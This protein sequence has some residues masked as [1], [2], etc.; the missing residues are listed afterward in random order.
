MP[1]AAPQP[2]RARRPPPPARPRP[3]SAR[4]GRARSASA[5]ASVTG[6]AS[7][8]SSS[9]RLLTEPAAGIGPIYQL[10]AGAR[11]SVDLTIYELNDP[12]AEAD[13]T[14]DAAR[15]VNVRVLLDQHLE[16]SRN[17]AAY[18]YLAARR[19]HVRWAPSGTTYHQKTLTVD[20]A[21]SVIMTLNLVAE[22]YP[23]TRDFAVIDTSHAD[24]A[25]IAATFDA[26]FAGRPIT[27][28][29]GTDLVWSPTNAQASL[30]SVIDNATHSLAVEDEEMDDPTVT[31]ALAAAAHRGVNVTITMTANSDWDSA[32]AQLAQAGAHIHLYPDDSSSLYIHAK[33]LVADAGR[34]SQQALVGSQNFSVAS[35]DYNR[36][37]GILT[38]AKPLITSLSAT[39]AS[40][41]SG[42][43]PYAP[44][45]TSTR[46]PA[47]ASSARCT[48]TAT[49][50]NAARNENNVYVHSNQPDQEATATAAGYSHTYRTNS[51]GYALIYLNGPSPGAR[52][53]VTVGAATCTTTLAMPTS[54]CSSA[55]GPHAAEISYAALE[56]FGEAGVDG[57]LPCGIAARWLGSRLLG[58][59]DAERCVQ[60]TVRIGRAHVLGDEQQYAPVGCLENGQ[61][62][63]CAVQVQPADR[64]QGFSRQ[65]DTCSLASAAAYVLDR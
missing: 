38:R 59:A 28:P 52:I 7:S 54:G 36:E 24:V 32:F 4:P 18:T 51:S 41:Y 12:T 34:P 29:D 35:L 60:Q 47:T 9:L 27:P 30:L 37:L 39:L 19:V 10:I 26:D 8:S 40:D 17:T 45:A 14:A 2:S 33:A 15:G 22:D 1:P 11:S 55:G 5:A 3:Q 64:R 46:S 57:W 49:V 44:A 58:F 25:A 61:E 50:Y 13:L 63:P 65:P 6:P 21:T 43:A 23:N 20:N 16:K 42:A 48:A 62:S 31:A 56:A 53:T